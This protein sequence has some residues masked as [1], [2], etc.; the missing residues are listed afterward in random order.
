MDKRINI[1]EDQIKEAFGEFAKAGRQ[2]QIINKIIL[3]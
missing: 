3:A 1:K 2:D